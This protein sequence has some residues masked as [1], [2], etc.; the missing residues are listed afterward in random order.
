M[1]LFDARRGRSWAIIV[2]RVMGEGAG[3]GFSLM[4]FRKSRQ[5]ALQS[6]F[7]WRFDEGYG[8]IKL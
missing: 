5:D 8:V 2:G 7:F 4:G 6:I 1:G 3:N